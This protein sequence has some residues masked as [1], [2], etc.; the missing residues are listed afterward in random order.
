MHSRSIALYLLATLSFLNAACSREPAGPPPPNILFIAVDDLNDWVIPFEGHPQAITPNLARLAEQSTRFTNAHCQ[1]PLC[2]PSRASLFT[3]LL[4]STSGIY[5]HVKDK[6]I[7]P[8][9]GAPQRAEFLT[10]VLQRNGYKTLGAGKLLHQGAGGQLLEDYAGFK[11]FG[12]YP[13]KHLNYESERTSTDWGAF[14]ERNDQ[15]PDHAVA[16]YAI[17]KLSEKH[18]VPFFLGVGINRPHV[19]WHVPQEWFDKFD[20]DSIQLPPYLANDWDDLPEISKRIHEAP[21]T[22]SA[23]WMIANHKWKEVVQ[24]YLACVAYADYEIGRV[25]DALATSPYADNT[26]I[27][28]WSDHGYHLGEKNIV[29]KMTLWEESTRV[30]LLIA[31]PGISKNAL[32]ERPVGL[33]D[34]YPTLLDLAGI[35]I[36]DTLDGR[37]LKPL[38]EN[39]QAEW[40]HPTLTIWGRNNVAV[41]DERY[42]YIR[43]EDGSEELYDRSLDPNE[44][45]NIANNPGF[46]SLKKHLAAYIP[47]SQAPVLPINFHQWN[48]YWIETVRKANETTAI[49][50]SNTAG[51]R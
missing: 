30:P 25:L 22:P 20:L 43:Y 11:D 36:P 16:N 13:E 18:E 44:F 33:I 28:L 32:S 21:P 2:G 9:N 46:D 5:L 27:V 1:A 42:R 37:S 40:D 31:G 6:E 29:T 24:A 14:P 12:P 10:H 26:L 3:G 38:L 49:E 15:M 51:E 41:R 23:E 34:L 19:P 50:T 4:P 8:Q 48:P 17:K 35:D 47:Q 45:H 39:P 7:V